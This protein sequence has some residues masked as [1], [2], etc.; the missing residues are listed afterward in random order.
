MGGVDYLASI[1][2]RK[3]VEVER[4]L[5]HAA[6]RHS[7]PSAAGAVRSLQ[8]SAASTRSGSSALSPVAPAGAAA[9]AIAALRREPGGLPRVIAEIKRR[10]PSA[11]E[12]RRRE[13]GDVA[14]LASAYVAGGA[15]AISVLCD[16]PGF[17][18][19]AL[20]LRRAARAVSLPILFKEFVL[21]EVQLDLACAVGASMALLIVRALTKE[22]L[23][24]LVRAS[25]ERGLAPVVEAADADELQIALET[26]AEIVGVNAR[27]LGTFRVDKTAAV[28]ALASIPAERIAI[29][30]S[31]VHGALDLRDVAS[32]RADAVLV[33]ESLMRAPDPTRKLRELLSL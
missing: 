13:R 4:R 31:G 6:S 19:S 3:R 5:R 23:H 30:M 32:G 1:L 2:E 29:H 33:G 9:R 11:G 25:Y 27:D 16:G 15:A 26:D 22:R 17:G 10:S 14:Q 12:I 18:G 8:P 28:R 21:D 24:A 7:Q 20:D